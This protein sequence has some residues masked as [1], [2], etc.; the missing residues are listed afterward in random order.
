MLD[1]LDDVLQRVDIAV[2]TNNYVGGGVCV[3]DCMGSVGRASNQLSSPRDVKFDRHANL[4]VSDQGNHRV[5]KF[6]IQLPSTPCVTRK[7][8]FFLP[9]SRC[10][11]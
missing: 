7:R 2:R 10:V 9:S 4:Y 3:I 6:L 1:R 5:Q 8:T 11:Y